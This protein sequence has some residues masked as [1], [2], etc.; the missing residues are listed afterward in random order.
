MSFQ[1]FSN[2]DLSSINIDDGPIRETLQM[3]RHEVTITE[4][5]IDDGREGKKDLVL[6]YSNDKGAIR[7]WLTIYD[8]NTVKNDKGEAQQPEYVNINWTQIKKLLKF[9]GHEA[10]ETPDPSYFVGKN[11]GINV[12]Q[13]EYKGK[14]Q[15]RINYHFMPEA[16]ASG[17]LN[18]NIPF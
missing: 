9:I 4:A 11:V 3:G 15:L 7:Q 1:G 14:K 13:S 16:S 8:P 10:D 5:S 12:K 18:D 2:V 17:G 6:S